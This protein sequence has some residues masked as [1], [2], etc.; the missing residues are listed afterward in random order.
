MKHRLLTLII[1]LVIIAP[2]LAY[3]VYAPVGIMHEGYRGIVTS[4]VKYNSTTGYYYFTLK[5]EEHRDFSKYPEDQLCEVSWE[6]GDLMSI[7]EEEVTILVKPE[8]YYLV[9]DLKPGDYVEVRVVTYIYPSILGGGIYHYLKCIKKLSEAQFVYIWVDK[10]CGAT[11]SVGEQCIIYF[12]VTRRAYI[13]LIDELPGGSYKI[14]AEGWADPGVYYIRG[15]VG[16]PAGYRIFHIYATDTAGITSY[17]FC[18]IVVSG[19]VYE[20]Y[21]YPIGLPE[22]VC[23]KVY[24]DGKYAGTL[25]SGSKLYLKITTTAPKY[26]VKVDEVVVVAPGIRYRALQS[27]FTLDRSASINIYY[28]KEVKVK[29]DAEPRVCD[30]T[31]G[32]E[33]YSPPFEGWLPVDVY[34]ISVP[35]EVEYAGE[36]Y[37][38]VKW[39]DGSTEATRTIKIEEP[40][41]L[42]AYFT[43]AHL[44][45]VAAKTPKGVAL[46]V[47]VFINDVKYSTKLSKLFPEGTYVIKVNDIVS[48]EEGVRYLFSEWEDGVKSNERTI[49]LESDVKLSAIY[50]LQYYVD[51]EVKPSEYKEYLK[52]V[53]VGG[54]W[55]DEGSQVTLSVTQTAVE[56]STGVRLVFVKW[57]GD[58]SSEESSTTF[59]VYEPKK[60]YAEWKKQYYL[61][62]ISQYGSPTGGGWYDEGSTAVVKVEPVVGFLIEYHFVKWIVD[63]GTPNEY[64]VESPELSL[65][66]NAPH[67]VKAVWRTDYTKLIIVVVVAAAAIIGAILIIL[68]RRRPLPPPP[69]PCS[70]KE[71]DKK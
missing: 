58:I 40:L 38:F 56:V 15:V 45:E 47:P 30:I 31:I 21:L 57:S 16:E 5:V 42:K 9:K 41:K 52:N 12:K 3:T 50:K 22:G 25:C 68:L 6:Q 65:T 10:G 13:K 71:I 59:K 29:I 53:I 49:K 48:V 61:K 54:G 64:S 33:K 17:S 23:V 35:A 1:A 60:V 34:T 69:P 26:I 44:L 27:E 66:M 4:Y 46:T 43:K 8:L 14:L 11:Y 70:L 19:H 32:T 20:V 63:E 24:V 7:I 18:Y 28:V 55:Y 36:K 39:S 51:V 62:V 2:L 67:T 37:V